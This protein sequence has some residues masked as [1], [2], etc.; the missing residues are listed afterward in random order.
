MTMK[1]RVRAIFDGPRRLAEDDMM[2]ATDDEMRIKLSGPDKID[3]CETL[4]PFTDSGYAT[5]PNY[6]LIAKNEMTNRKQ[7]QVNELLSGSGEDGKSAI[8]SAATSILLSLAQESISEVCKDVYSKIADE[9]CNNT[10]NG[11]VTLDAL[12]VVIKAF[13][14]KLGTSPPNEMN[15]RIMH[16]VYKHH[17]RISQQLEAMFHHATRDESEGRSNPLGSMS[18]GDKMD[19]WNR[20]STDEPS[21]VNPSDLFEG[22]D[23]DDE[24]ETHGESEVLAY[25]KM[26]FSSTA[27]TCLIQSLLKQSTQYWDET[28]PRTMIDVQRRVLG[29]LPAENISK[30]RDPAMYGATFWLSWRPILERL[31]EERDKLGTASIGKIVVLTASSVDQVQAITIRGYLD[32]TW[33]LDGQDLLHA[34]QKIVDIEPGNVVSITRQ[35]KMKIKATVHE[36]TLVVHVVGSACFLTQCGEQTA[37]L[38]AA[39]QPWRPSGVVHSTPYLTK[40]PI[41]PIGVTTKPLLASLWVDTSSSLEILEAR[42]SSRGFWKGLPRHQNWAVGLENSTND[43]PVI[44]RKQLEGR[45][46]HPVI[47]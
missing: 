18:L 2:L 38:G 46:V 24:E 40:T 29:D 26:I 43:V 1:Q 36:S 27:Y 42:L 32:Q 17:G 41:P 16:F 45:L 9:I 19:L 10:N 33:A 7:E 25:S 21:K 39:L 28:Q 30:R 23:D 15:R 4:A 20:R 13:A 22:V 11:V 34:L 35:D 37:W 14:I 31:K 47:V 5:L 8:F 6:D 12:P 44:L 3:Q